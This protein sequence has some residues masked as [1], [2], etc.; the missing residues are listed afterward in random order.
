VAG[1]LAPGLFIGFRPTFG[2]QIVL[3]GVAA[4]FLRLNV[5]LAE[6]PRLEQF[7]GTMTGLSRMARR[8]E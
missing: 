1:G 6:L 5:L 8:R 2:A 4:Y 3:A 7:M